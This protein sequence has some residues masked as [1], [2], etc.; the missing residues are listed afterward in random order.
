MECQSRF[1]FEKPHDSTHNSKLKKIQT[2]MSHMKNF[3]AKGSPFGLSSYSKIDSCFDNLLGYLFSWT[4][5]KQLANLWES[6]NDSRGNHCCVIERVG[7]IIFC[8]KASTR[9]NSNPTNS[10]KI[11]MWHIVSLLYVDCSKPCVWSQHLPF[12]VKTHLS[13]FLLIQGL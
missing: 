7:I 6:S 12:T 4:D 13:I 3:Y 9:R 2:I 8:E 1:V 11:P 10:Y 5:K